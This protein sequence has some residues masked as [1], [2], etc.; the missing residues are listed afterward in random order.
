MKLVEKKPNLEPTEP[1]K[2]ERTSEPNQV[3]PNTNL[4]HFCDKRSW[5]GLALEKRIVQYIVQQSII[6]HK[7]LNTYICYNIFEYHY[8]LELEQNK[9]A[10]MCHLCAQNFSKWCLKM[11][12]APLHA[13]HSLCLYIPQVLWEKNSVDPQKIIH[14]FVSHV[15]TYWKA[16]QRSHHV[17][18]Q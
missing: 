16:H 7:I 4:A 18:H 6:Y 8:G 13:M 5:S 15:L 12:Q 3:R 10:L 9:M 1:Q 14:L 11:L 17:C 2:T